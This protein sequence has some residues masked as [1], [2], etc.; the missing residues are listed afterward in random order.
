MICCRSVGGFVALFV[1]AAQR[2][3]AHPEQVEDTGIFDDGKERGRRG[4]DQ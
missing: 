3:V 1:V 2:G 4:D